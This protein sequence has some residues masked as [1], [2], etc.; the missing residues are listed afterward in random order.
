MNNYYIT[1][2]DIETLKFNSMTKDTLP[3]FNKLLERIKKEQAIGETPEP[4]QDYRIGFVKR[5]KIPAYEGYTPR[6]GID[7]LRIWSK[8]KKYEPDEEIRV[9]GSAYHCYCVAAPPKEGG[10]WFHDFYLKKE[11]KK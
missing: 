9:G 8:T 5:E 10:D 4:Y 3:A 1:D 11:D 2:K 6:D 7:T